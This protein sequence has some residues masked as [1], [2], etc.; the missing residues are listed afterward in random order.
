MEG[1]GAGTDVGGTSGV[2]AG[3]SGGDPAL[4]LVGLAVQLTAGHML[5]QRQ[6]VVG[7]PGPSVR[8]GHRRAVDEPR[9]CQ[10]RGDLT[11][12]NEVRDG[13]GRDTFATYVEPWCLTSQ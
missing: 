7:Q 4:L 12:R 1:R 5:E 6:G 3:Q 2:D 10:V 8:R 11:P 13:H 9:L